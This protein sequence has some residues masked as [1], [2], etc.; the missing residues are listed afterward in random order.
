MKKILFFALAVIIGAGTIAAQRSNRG[1]NITVEQRVEEMTKQ[2][3]LTSEQ[4]TK[5]K[6]I[7]T[8]HYGKQKQNTGKTR[9]EMRAE[10]EKL[11]K[12]VSAV[13]TDEQKKKYQSMKQSRRGGGKR[14]QQGNR[15]SALPF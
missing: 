7:Y 1:E 8:E 9:E 5:I 15:P 2:L 10:R 4:Q 11:D 12:D 13:L 6:A 3:G 14:Q